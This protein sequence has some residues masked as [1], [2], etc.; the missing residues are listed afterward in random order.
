MITIV[1]GPDR[2]QNM[3]TIKQMMAA[4]QP[5]AVKWCDFLASG[6]LCFTK[7]RT[8]TTAV[9]ICDL[10]SPELA[11]LTHVIHEHGIWLVQADRFVRIRPKV[12]ITTQS[13]CSSLI[14]KRYIVVKVHDPSALA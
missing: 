6:D 2:E 14:D 9:V 4:E 1:S 8:S 13:D 12:F 11:I 3:S 5:V 7:A 10:P